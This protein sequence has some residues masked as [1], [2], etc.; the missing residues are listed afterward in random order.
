MSGL[1]ERTGARAVAAAVERIARAAQDDAPGDVV[2]VQEGS[3]VVLS[4]RKL[5]ARSIDDA[6]LRGFGM[7]GGGK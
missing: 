1:A 3:T 4:G 5:R 7:A 2:V 6:R